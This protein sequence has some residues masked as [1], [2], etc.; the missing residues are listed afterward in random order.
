MP[1]RACDHLDGR[2]GY[3]VGDP[4]CDLSKAL[5]GCPGVELCGALVE[6]V[7][8]VAGGMGL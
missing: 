3:K 6:L 7:A 8:A 2:H 4:Q 1:S 5:S